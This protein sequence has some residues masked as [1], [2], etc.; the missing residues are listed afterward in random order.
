MTI[1][2][3]KERRLGEAF[4]EVPRILYCNDPTW[5]CPLDKEINS[6]FDSQNNVYFK[7][8]T[9]FCQTVSDVDIF[10]TRGSH[11]D[12]VGLSY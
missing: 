2:E 11:K 1:V 6:I 9:S 12:Q 8:F 5:V 10:S 4:L 3:V 7:R